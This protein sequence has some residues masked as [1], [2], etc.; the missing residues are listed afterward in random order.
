MKSLGDLLVDVGDSYLVFALGGLAIAYG[1]RARARQKLKEASP[2][3]K[4]A[5]REYNVMGFYEDCGDFYKSLYER[6]E[7]NV[8]Q[9]LSEKISK[10][11]HFKKLCHEYE[12]AG[13]SRNTIAE[14][15]LILN[16]GN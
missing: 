16:K 12:E 1:E 15:I 3:L 4:A 5:R 8:E 9:C 14:L 6:A 10:E 7:T 2:K 13:G 11:K